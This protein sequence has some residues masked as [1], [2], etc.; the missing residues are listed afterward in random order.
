MLFIRQE[1]SNFSKHMNKRNENITK[2]RDYVKRCYLNRNG[3]VT[4]VVSKIASSVF[5]S[6]RTIYNDIRALKDYS[7]L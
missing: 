3:T 6:E 5:M 2:R 4:E 1:A 7:Q